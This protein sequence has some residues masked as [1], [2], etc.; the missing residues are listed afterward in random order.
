MSDTKVSLERT[1]Y[2]RSVDL[3]YREE[4][5]WAVVRI[6]DG[7]SRAR[8]AYKLWHLSKTLTN[9]GP[10]QPGEA[11][12]E[13]ADDVRERLATEAITIHAAAQLYY[14][15]ARD[16]D[17]LINTPEVDDFLQ[18][19]RLEAAHQVQRWGD[20]HDRSKSAENWF[21]LV[22]YLA[23]KALRAAIGESLPRYKHLKRGTTYEV[24][25]VGEDENNRGRSLVVYRGEDDGKIWVRPAEQF[26]DGRFVELPA[27]PS[28]KALHHTI[29]AGAALFNWHKA[30]H[31]DK[32]G[33]G[34]G[35][36]PDLVALDAGEQ[37][38]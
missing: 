16:L 10:L 35:Q 25:S 17:Q 11:F 3:G 12:E 32:S 4:E 36:D 13:F 26:F 21:W 37:H 9:G 22:G 5:F 2:K 29:S 6:N 38:G 28:E 24:V 15:R 7:D 20:A 30:I 31:R 33:A 18:G 14:E 27:E 23:G 19:V 34:V 1:D 8:I